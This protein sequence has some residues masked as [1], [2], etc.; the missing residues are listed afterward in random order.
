MVKIEK[1][2]LKTTDIKIRE[3]DMGGGTKELLKGL[4]YVLVLSI[5]YETRG[6]E[7]TVLFG[8]SIILS[9]L[10]FFPKD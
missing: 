6:F 2:D 3:D 7:A 10:R 9:K 8:F 1:E 4:F 5:A